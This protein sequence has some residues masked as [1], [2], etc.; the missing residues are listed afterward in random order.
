MSIVGRGIRNAFRNTTRTVSVVLIL[1][2]AIG[3]AFVMLVAYRTVTD[4]VATTLSSIGN[5]VTIGPPGYSAGG[6]L[7]KDLTTA[8][9]APIAHL[10][11]VMSLDEALNG[12]VK[13]SN[14]PPNTSSS[15]DL[16][17][18]RSATPTGPA[19]PRAGENKL[20]STS[21]KYPGNMAFAT[22]GLACQPK[23]CTPPISYY[24]VYFSGSTQPTAPANIGASTLRIVSGRAISGSTTADV[25]MVSTAMA[26]KNGLKVGSTFTAY[27]ETFTVAAIFE[28]D[29]QQ[30]NDTVITS[31]PVLQRLIGVPGE[32]FNATVTAASL[33][34]LAKVTSEIEQNLGPRASVV[35]YLA[36]A[37]LAVGDLDSVKGIAL[38]SLVGTVGA[39]VVILF[40][41]MVLIVRERKREIGVLKAI[42]AS[43]VRIIVQF[44]TEAVTFTLFG[45]IVGAAIGF[46]G[47]GP[48]TSSLVSHSGVSADTGARGTFGAPSPVLSKLTDINAQV[49]WTVLLEGLAAALVIAVL[50]SVAAAWMIA[51][52]RPAEVL[53][54]E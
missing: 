36:D 47:A 11:G 22:A 5:T 27:G 51:R 4:K 52:I 43:N 25:A 3:L 40:F 21:L 20:G 34:D 38:D 16:P 49:G 15:K 13:A 19:G 6:L 28:S 7:G 10:P 26:R 39:A 44:T 14:L 33:S 45:L 17:G 35:S 18:P 29:T 42:G 23:P 46:I 30:G 41:V 32:V 37:E 54:S 53:R 2:L 24:S 8:E 1:G 31:L 50:A 9:L 48:I 12:I